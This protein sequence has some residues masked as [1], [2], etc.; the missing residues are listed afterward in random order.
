VT[1]INDFVLSVKRN[2][3][4]VVE[5]PPGDLFHGA[6]LQVE[7]HAALQKHQRLTIDMI[8]NTNAIKVIATGLSLSDY[9]ENDS[10]GYNFQITSTN[11]DYGYDNS[12]VGSR[13]EYVPEMS[14]DSDRLVSDFVVMRELNDGSTNS[15][16]TVTG[17]TETGE[18]SQLFDESLTDILLSVSETEDLEIE[19]FFEIELFFDY[20]HGT[21]TIH[22]KG[23][24]PVDTG[25]GI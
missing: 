22:V 19:D 8:K 20:A 21:T 17:Y 11:G 10:S 7:I 6:L 24:E 15:K 2:A 14:V 1:H 5:T 13:L 4:A 18:E 16:L 9:A 12:I 25:D 23:W 3:D